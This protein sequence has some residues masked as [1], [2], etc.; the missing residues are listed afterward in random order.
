MV[1]PR[2]GFAWG[3]NLVEAGNEIPG[4]SF[5]SFSSSSS[6]SFNLIFIHM[7]MTNS[8]RVVKKMRLRM[9]LMMISAMMNFPGISVERKGN[10][11][12]E[13]SKCGEFE[14][15]ERGG[16]GGCRVRAGQQPSLQRGPK[17]LI[18][19][20]YRDQKEEKMRQ[21]PKRTKKM[22]LTRTWSKS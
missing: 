20:M 16:G 7:R 6:I 17:Q 19:F 21:G 5:S 9:M 1:D 18:H 22:R 2:Y 11:L 8:V 12:P 4:H 3:G 10:S 13:K 14:G 15:V